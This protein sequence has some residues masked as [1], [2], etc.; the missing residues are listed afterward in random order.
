MTSDRWRRMTDLYEAVLEKAPAD[1]E[2]FLRE[3][4]GSDQQ[5]CDEVESLL[6]QD[7]HDSP[8][9]RPIWVSDTLANEPA[10]LAAG[11]VVGSFRIVGLIGEGGMGQVYRAQDTKLPR[12]VAL[13]ILPDAFVHDPDRLA[14]FRQEAHVLASLNHPNI[15]TIHG[16]ED[17]G[18]VHALVLELIEGPT[19]ADRIARGPMPLDEALPI[20]RQIAE[21]LEA[22][23]ERGIIHRDV[24]PANIK[25]RDDGAVKVLDFG[26]AKASPGAVEADLQVRLT[27]SPTITSPAMMTGVGMLLGTAA[28]MSPEQARGKPADKRSDIWAFGC[29]LF[30]MLTGRRAFEGEDVTETVAAVV[31]GEPPWNTLPSGLSRA[32]VVFLRRCLHKDA[33]QRLGDIRDMRLALEGAFEPTVSG[34]TEPVVRTKPMW[35]RLLPYAST[36][37]AGVLASAIVGWSFWPTAYPP[38]TVRFVYDLPANQS[39]RNAGRPVM[40]LSADGRRFVYNT[41]GGFFVRSFGTLEARLIPGTE[42]V[43]T[44]PFFSPDGNWVGYWENGQIKRIG[45]DGGAPVIIC[46]ATNP[47]GVSWE[48]DDT[49]LFGQ[50]AGIMRVSANGGSPQLVIPVKPSEAV[51]GPQLLPNA[52]SVLFS[53]TTASGDTRWDTADIVV[54]SLATGKRTVLLHGGSD[55]RFIRS[56][57]LLYALRDALYAVPFD[58]VRL[59]FTGGPVSV[60]QGIA[61]AGYQNAGGTAAGNYAV[62]DTG[63][64]V[65]LLAGARGGF[66]GGGFAASNPP[67]TL[68]WVDRR[69]NEQPLNVPPHA[70]VYA[71]ISPDGTRLALDARDQDQDIWIWEFQRQILIRLTTDP[72]LDTLPVWAQDGKRL[73]WSS[74]RG[75]N[76]LNL[77]WQ[78]A[79]GTGMAERLTDISNPQRATSFTPDGKTIVLAQAAGALQQDIVTLTLDGTR[80]VTPLISTTFD[81]GN[82]VVAP[83]GRWLAYESNESGQYQIYVRPFPTVNAGRWQVSTNGGRQPLWARSGEELFYVDPTGAIMRVNVAKNTASFTASAPVK[84]INGTGYYYAREDQNRGRTYDVSGDGQRFVRIKEGPVADRASDPTRFVIVQHWTEE[85]KRLVPTH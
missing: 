8:L 45:L 70:Y 46:A 25:L 56:G 50:P 58:P 75:G 66:A 64:F 3:S 48:S 80:H 34:S 32:C 42:P 20:A 5:L 55:A 63:T 52:D 62:S 65:F 12:E 31:R 23:H 85:L 49:I 10:A 16:F 35:R 18:A 41:T 51:Y 54:Q 36:A 83:D 38:A 28:Y 84:L 6:S 61:R 60:A 74:Q 44:S 1:R 15:A 13:K 22:A 7:R 14:R 72:A 19:L 57:H 40:A 82:G 71:R 21:A 26:L 30:E 59:Q 29:V 69:G 4:C 81:E 24:K 67:T 76:L 43:S 77:Y 79:D 39:F 9:D 33:R 47:F 78:N 27:Q 11:A 73:V 68:A 2:T 17:S 53:A 37:L